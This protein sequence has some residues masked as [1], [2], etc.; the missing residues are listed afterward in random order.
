MRDLARLGV[1]RLLLALHDVSF[2]SNADEDVGRGSP[3]TRAAERLYAYASSLGF[4]GIQLGPQGQTSRDNA[5]PYDGTIFSRH[6]GN[7]SVHSLRASGAFADLV[8][9]DVIDRS[10]ASSPGGAAHH[11]HAH[12]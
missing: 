10:V 9:D 7:L 6:L 1:K 3:V 12:D 11:H 4:T 5:S 2:P 8:A